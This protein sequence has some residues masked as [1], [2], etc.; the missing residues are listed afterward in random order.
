MKFFR[1]LCVASAVLS[2]ASWGF[3]APAT[4]PAVDY[5]GN[6]AKV[7]AADPAPTAAPTIAPAV[8]GQ[9]P[10]LLFTAADIETLKKQTETDPVLKRAAGD[11]L[12]WAKR[13]KPVTEVH[14]MII[15]DDTAA[16]STSTGSWA[17]LS[18]AYAL[19]KDPKIKDAIVSI[20]QMMIAEPYWADGA[21]L[22]SN[23]G[24]G[25]NM[26]MVGLLF[27]VV[28]DD[29]DPELREKIAANMLVHVR[30]M[31][32]L[33]HKQ[34]ALLANKYW[35]QDTQNNHRW[36][37]DAGMSACLLSIFDVKGIDAGFMMQEHKK[38]MDLLMKW[39]P[40]DGDCH[41]G[42][43]YQ[44]FGFMYLAAAASMCD[45]VM[46]TDYLKHPGFSNSWA[47][48]IYYAAPGRNSD[49]SFGDDMNGDGVFGNLEGG[50]FIGP[51]IT[52]DKNVQAALT[53]RLQTK[54][55]R[56]DGRPDNYPWSLLA[57]YDPTLEGGDYKALP[58]YKLFEDLGAASMRDTWEDNGVCLTFKCGPYGGYK[59]SEY[60]KAMTQGD[61][62]LHYINVAHDDP[63]AN[64]FALGMDGALMFHPGLY[65][66]RKITEQQN[67]VTI[68]GKGQI[69]EG[70]DFM[71]PVENVDMR[72]LSYLT[73]WKP[74][75][76]GRAIVEGE[77]SPAYKGLKHFRR[78]A[79]FMP[80]EYILMLDD[81]LG[82]AARQ[83]AWRGTVEK[84]QFDKPETGHCHAYTKSGKQLDFQMLANKDFD[85]AIDFMY[86]DGRFGGALMQQFQFS[87]NSESVKFACLMDPWKKKP[88]MTLKEVGDTVT[89]TVK[90]DGIDDVW[91]WK[92]AKDGETPSQLTCTRAGAELITLEEKDKATRP[93]N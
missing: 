77:A 48:Q 74:G 19:S 93:A 15:R 4:K 85:G 78:T 17:G 29:L 53:R 60:R 76:K 49:M 72:T 59:L 42:A 5:A 56:K 39:W 63:D 16:L 14:P 61:D 83:I 87:L 36:H 70:N 66:F 71:Q 27:D 38:E 8:A 23:M 25:N 44:T 43:G 45:R 55:K 22:D 91:T 1:P 62:K 30:R 52:R 58:T 40:A 6:L 32:Y 37:R 54:V 75:E 73:G 51:K 86:L 26:F 80:G 89:L 90:A 57:F 64:S 11:L 67:A 65:S 31:Y 47:Q 50:F 12:T 3:A 34:G 35:Q 24:A 69:N 13:M 84:G 88:E 68:D 92:P 20:L 2:L 28:H 46:G 82:D 33:G 9:H 81:I 41:E 10:R 79:V 18:Y 7:P 21:E